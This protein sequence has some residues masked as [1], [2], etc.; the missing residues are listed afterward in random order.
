MN[1]QDLIL[2]KLAQAEQ[3][4]SEIRILVCEDE[5]PD[6]PQIEPSHPAASIQNTPQE[7]IASLLN[8]ALD[9]PSQEEL[10]PKLKILLHSDLGE[11]DQALNSMLRFNWSNLLRSVGSYLS[12]PKDPHSFEI[13]REQDRAFADVI[14]RKVYLKCNNRKPVPLNL[15]K[16]KD[17]TWKIYSISL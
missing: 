9:P 11:N 10:L 12:S 3:L 16:D 4:L 14:E 15:R 6:Q 7:L 8:L 17:N 2:A 13:V 1:K 5:I